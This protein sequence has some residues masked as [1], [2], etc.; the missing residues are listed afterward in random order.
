MGDVLLNPKYDWKPAEE[1]FIK[2]KLS[3]LGISAEYGIPYQ[4]VRQ[5]AADHQ[6]AVKRLYHQLVRSDS[7]LEDIAWL[8][9]R[10]R[11]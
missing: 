1:S 8:Q 9:R 7:Q 4:T 10:L 11:Y 5:Y 6:W 3:L 2:N